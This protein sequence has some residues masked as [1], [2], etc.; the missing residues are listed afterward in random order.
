MSETVSEEE[1]YIDGHPNWDNLPKRHSTYKQRSISE[2]LRK[3]RTKIGTLHDGYDE[4]GFDQVQGMIE[5][6]HT[7]YS[8]IIAKLDEGYF[9]ALYKMQ[10]EAIDAE[11]NLK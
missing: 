3:L 7:E 8:N 10:N 6:A 9:D 1:H 5:D 2:D 4:S 11:Y